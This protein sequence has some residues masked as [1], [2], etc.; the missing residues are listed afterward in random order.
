MAVTQIEPLTKTGCSKRRLLPSST[1]DLKFETL[2]SNASEY[3]SSSPEQSPTIVGKK[4]KTSSWEPSLHRTKWGEQLACCFPYFFANRPQLCGNGFLYGDVGYSEYSVG[5]YPWAQPLVLSH[6]NGNNGEWTNGDDMPPKGGT[7]KKVDKKAKRGERVVQLNK[8]KGFIEGERKRS[9]SSAA[10]VQAVVGPKTIRGRGDYEMGR[11]VGSRVGGWIG[12]KLHRWISTITG[13]GDYQMQGDSASDIKTNSLKAGSSVPSMHNETNGTIDI[14]FKEFITNVDHTTAFKVRSIPIDVSNPQFAPWLSN[15]AKNFQQYEI[16]GCV[17]VYNSL[18]SDSVTAPTPGMGSIFGSVRYDTSSDAPT[19]KA[20]VLNNLFSSSAKPSVNQ[21]FPIECAKNMTIISPMKIAA[22][23]TF[24]AEKQF[25]QMGWFDLCS[26]GANAPYADVGELWLTIHVRLYKPRL[27]NT[28]GG[29]IFALDVAPT[30]TGLLGLLQPVIDTPAVKQPRLNSLGL[31]LQPDFTK[32]VFPLTTP[33]NSVFAVDYLLR[34]D[35]LTANLF[36]PGLGLTGGFVLANTMISQSTSFALCPSA[37]TN[38]GTNALM[39]R[40][41]VFYNGTGTANIPPTVKVQIGTAG[42]N[43]TGVIGGSFVVT[44]IDSAIRSGLVSPSL[45]NYT[46]GEFFQFLCDSVAGRPFT[47]PPGNYRLVDWTTIFQRVAAIDPAQPIPVSSETFDQNLFQA[48]GVMSK[49]VGFQGGGQ[50]TPL[51]ECK[52]IGAGFGAALDPTCVPAGPCVLE[53]IE[54][55]GDCCHSPTIVRRN[56]RIRSQLNGQNGSVKG[57]CDVEG[58]V[59]TS[60]EIDSQII[61]VNPKGLSGNMSSVY[62]IITSRANNG[63]KLP[64]HSLV[65][66]TIPNT[67]LWAAPP[68]LLCRNIDSSLPRGVWTIGKLRNVQCFAL[69]GSR[70]NHAFSDC[71]AREE[72]MIASRS[73]DADQRKSLQLNGPNGTVNGD[74]NIPEAAIN[75]CGAPGCMRNRHFHAKKKGGGPPAADGAAQRIA[76]KKTN[77]LELCVMND[78]HDTPLNKGICPLR[79]LI[80]YHPIA[81]RDILPPIGEQAAEGVFDAMLDVVEDGKGHV[82]AR[83]LGGMAARGLKMRGGEEKADEKVAPDG[84]DDEYANMP[85]EEAVIDG[86]PGAVLGVG[87][88][89][90]FVPDDDDLP[91]RATNPLRTAARAI[92]LGLFRPIVLWDRGRIPD[93]DA[94]PAPPFFAP[95]HAPAVRAANVPNAPRLPAPRMPQPRPV[96]DNLPVPFIAAPPLRP[97]RL[98]ALPAAAAPAIPVA[99][100]APRP[101]AP[102]PAAPPPGP[103]AGPPPAPPALAAAGVPAPALVPAAQAI[104]HVLNLRNKAEMLWLHKDPSNIVDKSIVV[105]AL[106]TIA[107]KDE[108]YKTIPDLPNV[109]MD[110]V[111][112]AAADAI[113]ARVWSADA[114]AACRAPQPL[115]WRLYRYY[116]DSTPRR[117]LFRGD[118]EA[119]KYKEGQE[120]FSMVVLSLGERKIVPR[121]TALLTLCSA[122]AAFFIGRNFK[123]RLLVL[124]IRIRKFIWLANAA[125]R[126]LHTSVQ[127]SLSSISMP[128]LFIP[129][130][131]HFVDSIVRVSDPLVPE[132]VQIQVLSGIH[133]LNPFYVKVGVVLALVAAVRLL[134]GMTFALTRNRPIF[135]PDGTLAADAFSGPPD[136]VAEDQ[137]LMAEWFSKNSSKEHAKLQKTRSL[138]GVYAFYLYAVFIAPA[139]EELIKR[140]YVWFIVYIVKFVKGMTLSSV[141]NGRVTKTLMFPFLTR[142]SSFTES[143]FF[144]LALCILSGVSFANFENRLSYPHEQFFRRTVRKF[145][146]SFACCLDYKAGT[147]AHMAWNFLAFVYTEAKFR[148]VYST[149]TD[150]EKKEP[151]PVLAVNP[152]DVARLAWNRIISKPLRSFELG[153]TS[154]ADICLDEYK[155]PI[156]RTQP[157]FKVKYG[158]KVC[159]VGHG[160]TKSWG[161]RGYIG[162]VFRSCHHNEAISL[163]GRVGKFLPAHVDDARFAQIKANWVSL[164]L[165]SMAVLEAIG[166]KKQYRPMIFE[167]WCATFAPARRDMMLDIAAS[168]KDMPALIA[169]SFIKKEIAVKLDVDPVFKDPRWIQGCPPELSARVGPYLRKWAK[170]YRD[171][172]APD[173]SV[174]GMSRG[175]QVVYTCGLNAQEIGAAFHNAITLITETLS[176]GEQV[177]FVEDDQSRFDLHMMEGPFHFL[178]KLY[179]RYLPRRVASLLR[180][181]RSRGRSNLGTTYSIDYTMQSGWPDTSLGDSA[182]NVAMKFDVH[183][184]GRRWISIVCG[185]DSITI[186]VDSEVALI[187]GIDGIV[188]K[189]AGYGME[190]EALL[191]H[192]PLD[193]EFCSGRFYPCSGS[194]TLMPRLGRLLSKIGWDMV[195]RSSSQRV[196]WLRS[197]ANTLRDYGQ[198]DPTLDALADMIINSVGVGKT[199]RVEDPYKYYVSGI[200]LDRPTPIDVATYHDHHYSHSASDIA[201]VCSAIRSSRLG[202]DV[203]DPRLLF[204]AE[205]DT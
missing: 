186:T 87:E 170:N 20:E 199:M 63:W 131:T 76:R 34:H 181:G 35:G 129:E 15:I 49:Y 118:V 27:E 140:V 123:V 128:D 105:R 147:M 198:I 31:K 155:M 197:I 151:I 8:Q 17:F 167:D 41:T 156:A 3:V 136:D 101:P 74:C 95:P 162:T 19:N 59:G 204:M 146:H 93:L 56:L 193:A 97:A 85:Y 96:R 173:W 26:E 109:I 75:A 188:D 77:E 72:A 62:A 182:V 60:S 191:R 138:K 110:V 55:Y 57:T 189:Y 84:D 133:N 183:G 69:T 89:E 104:D 88:D 141:V 90:V 134:K 67:W 180:R 12:E 171:A 153:V 139:F 48:L 32:V 144:R 36:V 29:S 71:P 25:Y 195:D 39:I 103:P 158:E 78:G 150:E 200:L 108:V 137:R 13:S 98:P 80:H 54:D 184:F 201:A 152:V 82:D 187:G 185:D 52:V 5:S 205:H 126:D 66:T 177:V 114:T 163:C 28:S 37:S 159:E 125:V 21:M 94:P 112:L 38:T 166:V 122:V 169:S 178:S 79:G 1:D 111:G 92:K 117:V 91:V 65:R 7:K 124:L 47:P 149:L 42:A 68:K 9:S 113:A 100:P 106:T 107:R 58:T 165:R 135:L 30:A 121:L 196:V 148:Y 43:P 33:V 203:S 14:S 86:V 194:Y 64:Q 130:P 24:P 23:G 145:G 142:H 174:A 161:I 157:G 127:Q 53:D 61:S 160:C 202:E 44:Q 119:M 40:A 6:I 168:C 115:L 99:F 176:L 16:M 192:D 175:L 10:R 45:T 83:A 120:P 132:V 22:P 11:S 51:G 18:T 46:R 81:F 172:I 116:F 102:P 154:N 190:V 143:P 73:I 70:C 2:G 50:T 164:S 179:R 4:Q